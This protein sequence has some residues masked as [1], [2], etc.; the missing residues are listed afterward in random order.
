[1][2]FLSRGVVMMALKPIFFSM[3][4]CHVAVAY[5]DSF[6]ATPLHT[7]GDDGREM[8]IG[9]RQTTVDELTVQAVAGNGEAQ[10]DLAF[11]FLISRPPLLDLSI[12][13]YRVAA[14]NPTFNGR[15]SAS[16]MLACA[17][18]RRG[19]ESDI[20]EAVQI[21]SE[22]AAQG[23]PHDMLTF[24]KVFRFGV[25]VERN[26][27]MADGWLRKS[28]DAYTALYRSLQDDDPSLADLVIRPADFPVIY[29]S[30]NLC[31]PPDEDALGRLQQIHED[32]P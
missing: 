10:E 15:G 30:S 20:A 1:M 31:L 29:L 16:A 32:R 6:G 25:G 12:H 2:G 4:V 27:M 19:G 5:S 21:L 26:A 18:L 8:A 14:V 3:L 23:Y 7:A 9:G 17:L 11:H 22:R 24:S 13:W 28:I